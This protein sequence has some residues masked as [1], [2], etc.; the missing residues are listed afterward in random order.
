MTD[1]LLAFD[2]PPLGGG[3][4]RWMGE[5]ARRYPHGELVVSTGCLEGD[6][7]SD[8]GFPNRVDRVPVPASRL[9]TLPGLIRWTRRVETLVRE[10]DARFLWCGNL[11]PA[12]YPAWWV[13]RRRDV[14]YGVIFHGGDLLTLRRNYRGSRFKR[15]MA[16]RLVAGAA[17][18]VV[19]SRFTRDLLE[20]VLSELAL[21]HRS[22]AIRVVPLGTDPELFRPDV[23]PAPLQLRSHLPPARW[24]VTVARLVPHKGID[25]AVRAFAELATKV[26]DLR[27]AVV[28]NGPYHGTLEALARE[29]GVADRVH[30]ISEASDADLPAWYALATVYLGLSRRT[31]LDVEGFGI[32]LVEAAAAGRP[33]VAGKSGGVPDAVQDGVTGLLVDP[34]DP[35]QVAAAVQSLLDDPGRAA[36]M[37]RAGR[38]EVERYYNWDR[39]VADLRVLSRQAEATAASRRSRR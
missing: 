39:V 35:H 28:G 27:Y 11:R 26:P 29:L 7:A 4:A 25:T 8:A 18:W 24:L 14:P 37:G 1:L 23:D 5:L 3:I 13:A 21:D 9:K 6:L 15:S 31:E 17:V 20:E 22:E 2:F 12:A 19:N 36:R 30:F 32:A 33:T 34:L 16:A 10:T 38:G